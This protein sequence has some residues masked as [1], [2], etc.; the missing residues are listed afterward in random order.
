Y[1]YSNEWE[2]NINKN[3]IYKI[4]NFSC[5]NGDF[6]PNAEIEFNFDLNQNTYKAKFSVWVL[7]DNEDFASSTTIIEIENDVIINYRVDKENL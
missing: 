4:K 5:V 2:I 1:V 7:N 6:D 3:R